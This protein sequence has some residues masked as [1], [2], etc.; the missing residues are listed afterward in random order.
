MPNTGPHGR[1]HSGPRERPSPVP[2]TTRLYSATPPTTPP[3]GQGTGRGEGRAQGGRSARGTACLALALPGGAQEGQG[4][5]T[6]GAQV[7]S[8]EGSVPG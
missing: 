7:R 3:L 6:R 1:T 2:R 4:R 8:P 5:R